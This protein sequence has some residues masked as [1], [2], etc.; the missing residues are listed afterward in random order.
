MSKE[1]VWKRGDGWLIHNPP[2]KSEQ[3]D[4]WIKEKEKHATKNQKLN[5]ES[6]NG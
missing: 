5:K 3:W 1:L 4:E 6:K 2:R